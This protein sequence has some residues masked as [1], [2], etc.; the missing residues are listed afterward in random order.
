[1]ADWAETAMSCANGS[2]LING[3]DGGASDGA[4]V[5]TRAQSA[6]ILTAFGKSIAGICPPGPL[7][8]GQ[9]LAGCTPPDFLL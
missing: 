1:M 3:H 4:G 6:Q 8:P 5:P 9:G 2:G 7:P